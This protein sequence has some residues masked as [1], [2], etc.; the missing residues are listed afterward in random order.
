SPNSFL[1]LRLLSLLGLT[2]C[3]AAGWY[4]LFLL[5]R[6][7]ILSILGGCA[8]LLPPSMLLYG[9]N[10]KPD[11]MALAMSLGGICLALRAIEKKRGIE[12]AA[13]LFACAI[14]YK[15]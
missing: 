3:F 13:L 10:S 1:P 7:R 6:N 8:V 14:C 4:S 11:S 12:F 9:T 5:T 15:Q 2:L